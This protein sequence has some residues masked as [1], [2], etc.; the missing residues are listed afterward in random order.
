MNPVKTPDVTITEKDLN[1]VALASGAG[2]VAYNKV[3][4]YGLKSPNDFYLSKFS[5]GLKYGSYSLYNE[6]LFLWNFKT[7][8]EEFCYEKI[9][10]TGLPEELNRYRIERKLLEN[11]AGAFTKIAGKYYFLVVTMEEINLY[12]EWTEFIVNEPKSD[13]LHGKKLTT[14]NAVLIRNNIAKMSLLVKAYDFIQQ[15][16]KALDVLAVALPLLAPKGA[17]K[18]AEDQFENSSGTPIKDE[19][20]RFFQSKSTVIALKARNTGNLKIDDNTA[21]EF[22]TPFQLEVNIDAIIQVYSFYKEQLKEFFGAEMNVLQG[23]PER[24]VTDEINQQQTITNN[25]LLHMVNV[26]NQDFSEV[27]K[28]FGL[29]IVASLVEEDFSDEVDGPAETKDKVIYE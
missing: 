12:H 27:N 26:R 15:M 2:S 6:A 9:E 5:N 16:Q 1:G 8:L 14:K 18:I 7:M 24:L 28:K 13:I 22:W 3:P 25:V 29:N 11:G 17:V 10:Y 23:K 21:Q 19:F 20:A 4:P